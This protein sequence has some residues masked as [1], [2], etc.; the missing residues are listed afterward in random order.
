MGGGGEA[1]SSR[2]GQACRGHKR[3]WS[4]THSDAGEKEQK[5]GD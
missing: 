5:L 4:E 3:Q 1:I 2:G